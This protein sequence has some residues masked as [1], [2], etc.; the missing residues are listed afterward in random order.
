MFKR[1]SVISLLLVL[2]NLS[3]KAQYDVPFSHYWAMEPYYNPATVGKGNKMNVVG[4][5]SIDFSGFEHNPQTAY[6]GADMPLYFMKQ[7]HGVGVSLLNDKI[8]LFTHQRIAGQYAFRYR[9]FGGMLSAGVQLGLLMENFDG[10]K[11]DVEDLM[12]RLFPSRRLV[13][14]LWIWVSDFIM[15]ITHGMREYLFNISTLLWYLLVK[16]TN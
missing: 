10:T 6:I 2:V 13:V 5:Y 3:T 1:F 4:A 14:T 16:P 11:L 9:L 8:G 12:I 7:F 15:F